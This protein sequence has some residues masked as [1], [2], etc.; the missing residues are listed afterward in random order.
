MLA[1][2]EADLRTYCAIKVVLG[3]VETSLLCVRTSYERF[4]LLMVC[5]FVPYWIV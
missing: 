5:R 4:E 3:F 1:I 2:S